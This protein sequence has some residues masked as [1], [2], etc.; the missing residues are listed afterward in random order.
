MS[1]QSVQCSELF[2]SEVLNIPSLTE[3]PLLSGQCVELYN[4]TEMEVNLD[5]F[6]IVLEASDY[7]SKTTQLSGVLKSG[8][9]F[10]VSGINSSQSL[11]RNG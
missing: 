8:E 7:T 2:I 10:V 9:T 6:E 3:Y 1:Q 5:N 4:P 11:L